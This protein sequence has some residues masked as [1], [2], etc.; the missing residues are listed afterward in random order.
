M[1]FDNDVKGTAMTF[2]HENL[3]RAQ[4]SARLEEA[5]VCRPGRQ[6]A[7]VLRSDRIAAELAQQARHATARTL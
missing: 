1:S 6:L 2:T 4:V 3:V 5:R 7:R